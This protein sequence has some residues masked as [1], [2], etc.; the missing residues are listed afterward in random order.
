MKVTGTLMIVTSILKDVSTFCSNSV[1]SADVG[2]NV[3]SS[4]P[5][6][7]GPNFPHNFNPNQDGICVPFAICNFVI[8][9]P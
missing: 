6:S 1:I 4:F 8:I 9:G 2:A 7:P 3:T 5:L